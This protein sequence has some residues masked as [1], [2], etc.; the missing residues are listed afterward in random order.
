MSII[1][2]ALFGIALIAWFVH[3]MQE[4][5]SIRGKDLDVPDTVRHAR[6]DLRLIAYLLAFAI[7]FLAIIAS[8][9]M[10]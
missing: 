1:V 9:M 5:E 10:R 8:S 4:R 6:Q 7:V 2:F 3:R